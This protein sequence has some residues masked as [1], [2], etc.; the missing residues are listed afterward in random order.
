MAALFYIP[1]S[2]VQEIQ[3]FYILVSIWGCHC[4]FFILVILL[5]MQCLVVA[6]ICISLM[7]NNVEHS[8]I[9]L[10]L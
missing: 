9:L 7:A 1:T 6:L 5:S 8:W 10:P 4:F 3:C 2:N